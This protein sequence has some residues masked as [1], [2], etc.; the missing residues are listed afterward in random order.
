MLSSGSFIKVHSRLCLDLMSCVQAV[1]VKLPSLRIPLSS[2]VFSLLE[3]LYWHWCPSPFSFSWLSLSGWERALLGI[4]PGNVCKDQWVFELFLSK[5]A[6]F[7][8]AHQ[9]QTSV[10]LAT[11]PHRSVHRTNYLYLLVLLWGQQ[12]DV[13]SVDKEVFLEVEWKDSRGL[14]LFLTETVAMELSDI[15]LIL[16]FNISS[17]EYVKHFLERIVK[18][19]V[20]EFSNF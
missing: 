15:F 20:K 11:G 18:R 6:F 16:K 13:L 14:I 8:W 4:H 9:A 1:G 2:T 12:V 10:V 19:I 3:I 7:V 5:Q 17:S